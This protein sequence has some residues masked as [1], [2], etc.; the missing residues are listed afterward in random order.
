MKT[1]EEIIIIVRNMDR[2]LFEKINK[3]DGDF[4]FALESRLRKN[5]KARLERAL[6]KADL[7]L[8]EWLMWVYEY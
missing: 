4:R 6:K 2:E 8:D 3:A 5:A 1:L 7:N